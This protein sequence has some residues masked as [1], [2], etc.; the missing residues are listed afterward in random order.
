MTMAATPSILLK[1]GRDKSLRRWHPWVFS[2]GVQRVDGTPLPGETVT[3]RSSSG[4]FLARAAYSP[5]SQIRARVWSFIESES[6]AA[7]F[8][9]KRL[10][11]A[12]ALRAAL[13]YLAGDNTACRLVNAESD[14]LPGLIIDRYGP[15]L[16]CQF[17][18]AG[19]EYWK[20]TLVNQLEACLQPLSI[21]ER[22]DTEA[23][24]KEGMEAS[25]GLLAGQEPDNLVEIDECG[26][27]YLVDIRHGHKTGF[28]LD[29]RD[30]RSLVASRV[31]G[32]HVLNCF[33]YTGGFGVAAL[34]GKARSVINVDSSRPALEVAEMNCLRNGDGGC[35]VELLEGDVF[36]VLREY[37]HEGRVFDCI[38]LDPPKFVDSAQHLNR[39]ARGYKDIN[40]LAFHLLKS[41]GSLFTFSCSGLIEPALFQKIIADAALDANR[42]ARII[43]HL[44]QAEDHPTSLAFPEGTYLKGLLCQV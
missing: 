12:I 23:R 14:G 24:H 32:A 44:N 31:A 41:G 35:D 25:T 1:P 39:A 37:V 15:H 6:I 36:Q 33:C 13:G 38:I 22:S 26:R 11:N 7:P 30:N 2:G 21:Y 27:R 10:E 8:F 3:I 19:A 17:L 42:P 28:Y 16:V 20:Q 29:Q 9:R 4:E 34:Q 40:R 43:R 5:Q 18:S